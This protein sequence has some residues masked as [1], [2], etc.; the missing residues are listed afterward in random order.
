MPAIFVQVMSTWT[1][2]AC[3]PY[4]SQ[5][6]MISQILVSCLKFTSQHFNSFT[7][8][9]KKGKKSFLVWIV[10]TIYYVIWWPFLTCRLLRLLLM[11]NLYGGC[12][13]GI[14]GIGLE[15]VIRAKFKFHL[16]SLHPHNLWKCMNAFPLSLSLSPSAMG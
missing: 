14:M 7:N 5:F 6:Q 16:D 1:D 12:A 15:W 3:W 11:F 4:N 2:F 13:S 9:F 10:N 8:S